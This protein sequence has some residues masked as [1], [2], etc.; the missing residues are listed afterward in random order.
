MKKTYFIGIDPG[1]SKI[2]GHGGG[3]AIIDHHGRSVETYHAPTKTYSVGKNGKTRLMIDA[4]ALYSRLLHNTWH[5]P[6]VELFATIEHPAPLPKEF[7]V[8]I[9]ATCELFMHYGTLNT[10]MELMAAT[11]LPVHPRSWKSGYHLPADKAAALNLARSMFPGVD[12]RNKQDHNI[13]EALLLAEYGRLIYMEK[14][15]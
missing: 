7:D 12:L 8:P 3:V 2:K 14:S 4:E 11:V 6:D 1:A 9:K 13:G 5:K 15:Q 10:V